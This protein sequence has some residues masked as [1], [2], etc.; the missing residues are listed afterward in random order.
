MLKQVFLAH[1]EPVLIEFS[2]FCHVFAPSRTLRAYLRAIWWNHLE[3]GRG[4][5][6]RGYIYIYI[7]IYIL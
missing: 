1:F 3:L 2:A 4:V 7:Y 6:I 5:Q